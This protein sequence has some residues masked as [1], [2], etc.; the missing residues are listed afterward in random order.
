[1]L[2]TAVASERKFSGISNVTPDT[3]V[4]SVYPLL[5]EEYSDPHPV[6]IFTD[7]KIN[8]TDTIFFFTDMSPSISHC[9]VPKTA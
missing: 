3:A 5:C 2:V 1:M 8:N 6:S 4:I 7:A 9:N